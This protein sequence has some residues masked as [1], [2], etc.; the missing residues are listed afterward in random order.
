MLRR[1]ERPVGAV[2]SSR[3][4]DGTAH[5]LPRFRILLP[6]MTDHDQTE[7]RFVKT[8]RQ[9]A[10]E[11]LGFVLVCLA[12]AGCFAVVGFVVDD[13]P[14]LFWIACGFVC[15]VATVMAIVLIREISEVMKSGA[16]W[17]VVVSDHTLTWNSPVP[18]QMKSFSLPLAEIAEIEQRMTQYNNSKRS[19][20]VEFFIKRT[21]G[22]TVKVDRQKSGI[23]PRKVF[24]ELQRRGVAF[25]ETNS[26]KGS[27][28]QIK[29]EA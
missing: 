17:S 20:K 27:K 14:T 8:A 2:A 25:R 11:K 5:F 7:V 23:A 3:E 22:D 1:R 26:V 21:D 6:R 29:A 9:F 4:R 13:L 28:L 15:L 12:V 10:L 16:D 24:L 19:P 18:E